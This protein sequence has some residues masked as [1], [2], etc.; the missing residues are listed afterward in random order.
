MKQRWLPV[1]VLGG[2]LLAANVIARWV[3]RLFGSNNDGF[4]TRIGMVA[5]ATVAVVMAVAA[6]WWAR[7]Q[8]MA[9]VLGDLALGALVGCLLSVLVGPLLVGTTPL[10]DG[11][12]FFINQ[13]LYFLG[14]A[15]AGTVFGLLVV[16]ALGRDHK[17]QS[18]K[19][20]E[21]QLRS[22]PRRVVRR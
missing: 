4:T 20:Y 10:R 22:R 3:V 8:P 18:W 14:I 19:R 16:M 2:A 11:V 17:A 1:G 6:F 9:R 15:A 5:L 7:R 12:D 21:E 13:I